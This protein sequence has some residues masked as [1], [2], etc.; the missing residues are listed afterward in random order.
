[1]S[2]LAAASFATPSERGTDDDDEPLETGGPTPLDA[3]DGG[4]LGWSAVAMAG[5]RERVERR[6]GIVFI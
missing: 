4:C 1:M 5:G 3:G 2:S 6:R